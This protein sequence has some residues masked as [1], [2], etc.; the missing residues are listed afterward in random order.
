MKNYYNDYALKWG[1]FTYIGT[2][3]KSLVHSINRHPPH[4]H[5][6]GDNYN[7]KEGK[8]DENACECLFVCAGKA[9]ISQS[10]NNR[11]TS[12]DF[13]SHGARAVRVYM[14]DVFDGKPRHFLG[15][16]IFSGKKVTK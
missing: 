11:L 10:R 13:C 6:N 16:L 1:I 8:T 4:S 14:R 3:K 12:R 5:N 2:H 7:G 15:F 9:G